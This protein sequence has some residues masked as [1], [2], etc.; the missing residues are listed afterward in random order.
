[1]APTTDQ[2]MGQGRVALAFAAGVSVGAGWLKTGSLTPEQFGEIFNYLVEAAGPI[3]LLAAG[4]W[5]LKANSKKSILQAAAQMPEVR[6]SGRPI[7]V[8]DQKLADSLP[9]N[10]V[11]LPK[12][13]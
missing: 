4:A 13:A 11:A 10:V 1:M 12:A 5:S 3:F 2:M 8:T 6:E 9:D 7:V